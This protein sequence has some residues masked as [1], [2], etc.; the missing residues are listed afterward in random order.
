MN[1]P[2]AVI[3]LGRGGYS[4]APKEQL[5]R[6]TQAVKSGTDAELVIEAFIDYSSPS[7]PDA[8]ASC[9][10]HSQSLERVL[11]TPV[12]LPTDRNLEHWLENVLQRW[13]HDH[14]QATFE[15]SLTEGIGDCEELDSALIQSVQ[16][17]L[18]Q[19]TPPLTPSPDDPNS[20]NWSEVPPHRYHVLFCQGP[21]C[22]AIGAGNVASHLNQCLKENK[23]L[24][25]DVLVVKT[26][27]LFPCN[28]GPVMVVYPDGVWY[29]SLTDEAIDEIVEQ[30]FIGGEVVTRYVHYPK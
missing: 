14:P 12:Y 19:P 21:R 18:H 6:L 25:K 22:N 23:L 7:L 15:L 5:E 24:Y 26:G 27:C 4:K 16:T 9:L 30:H 20:P 8:L 28:Q 11:V 17:F 2:T 1:K 29:G 3:L 13:L 10:S